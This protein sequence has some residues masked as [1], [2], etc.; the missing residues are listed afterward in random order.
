QRLNKGSKI[1]L[2]NIFFDTDAYTL[3]TE[4]EVELNTLVN[5]MNNNASLEVEIEG[6]TDN[7]GAESHN[8][9]LSENRA[10]AVYDFLVENGIDANRMSFKGFG[11]SQPI[12]TN[13]TEK[14]RATNRR[15]AFRVK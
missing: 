7:V 13:D 8:L 1:V 2:N 3:K 10:K 9:K 15:T 5:F 14:G 11:A 6:H 4:S 12:A